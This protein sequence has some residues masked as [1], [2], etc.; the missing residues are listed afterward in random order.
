MSNAL[1]PWLQGA[2]LL[3]FILQYY[4][5]VTREEIFLKEAFSEEYERYMQ[6]VPR[7]LPRL[8]HYRGEHSFHR[9]PDFRR[10]L[11]SE[12]RTLQAFAAVVIIILFRFFAG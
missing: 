12:T 10:G 2:A 3:F 6:K 4:L 9:D 5:I 1:F 11:R 7:F 8:N